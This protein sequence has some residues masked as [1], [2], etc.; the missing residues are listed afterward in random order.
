[1]TF[2]FPAKIDQTCHVRIC[3][4]GGEIPFAGHPNVG[5]ACVLAAAGEFGEIN[6]SLTVTFA[7]EAGLV[8]VAI[9]AEEGKIVSCEL[10]APQSPS[11]G[12]TVPAAV[13]AAAGSLKR[14]DL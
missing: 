14:A 8:S 3:T 4:P 6:S 2:V 7:E 11:L 5:T 12:K 13:V 10:A 9:R 1:S